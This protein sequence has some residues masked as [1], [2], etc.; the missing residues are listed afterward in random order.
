MRKLGRTRDQRRALLKSLAVNLI[1]KSKIKTTEARAKESRSLIE[2]L[3]H[4][5]KQGDLAGIRYAAKYLPSVAVKKLSKDVAP[6]Y[7]D[8][9]GGYI[10]IIK[11]GQ[12]K[13]DGAMMVIMELV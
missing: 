3:I 2:R 1:M 7:Q 6:Q 11:L 10:R 12:R 8:R 13:S 9:R 4:R 5:A